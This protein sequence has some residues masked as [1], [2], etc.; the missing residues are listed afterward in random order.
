[1]DFGF[2]LPMEDVTVFDAS[3]YSVTV[4][5]EQEIGGNMV[6]IGR[7]TLAATED[8]TFALPHGWS[9]SWLRYELSVPET[10]AP[11]VQADTAVGRVA[12][13]VQNI[14]A[15]EVTLTAQDS[16]FAYIPGYEYEALYYTPLE[17]YLPEIPPRPEV[18]TG[19]LSFL[20]NEYV[21]TLAIP[22][23]LSLPTLAI[24]FFVVATR[25]KRR[26]RKMLRQRRTRF[27]RYPHYRYKEE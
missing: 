6:E 19:A 5:V 15:G 13:Y 26:L 10:L 17:L 9:H 16:V 14:R 12:V 22:L 24:S 25:H 23:S 1:L 11:P 20:N 7:V 8:L 2:S 27:N 4:P 3:L 21:L 18:F